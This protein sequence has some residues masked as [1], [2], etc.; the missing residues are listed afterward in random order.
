MAAL[1]ARVNGMRKFVV[2][3][4]GGLVQIIAVGVLDGTA[5]HVTEVVSAVLTALLVYWVPNTAVPKPP[6]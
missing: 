5:R 3:V 4:S 2:A 6:A 1:V